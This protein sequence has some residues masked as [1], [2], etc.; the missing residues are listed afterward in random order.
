M[1]L[2][3]RCF[4]HEPCRREGFIITFSYVMERNLSSPRFE[5]L[6]NITTPNI[7][8]HPP[9]PIHVLVS[10]NHP[11]SP[12]R[13]QWEGP[14]Q[15]APSPFLPW[16]FGQGAAGGAGVWAAIT[17]PLSSSRPIS[18][19]ALARICSA[20]EYFPEARE[21]KTCVTEQLDLCWAA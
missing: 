17:L 13:E 20:Q 14:P 16:R 21:N 8:C 4:L 5:L 6:F 10:I 19:G 15:W 7:L 3:L 2:P 12:A 1:P 11:V 18:A 9:V